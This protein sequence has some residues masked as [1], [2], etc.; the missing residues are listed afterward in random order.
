MGDRP[1]PGVEPGSP[2]LN[3]D[4]LL[5]EPSGKARHII[6]TYCVPGMA[7]EA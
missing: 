4:S 1:E 5:S 3:V 2:A 7:K 6:K